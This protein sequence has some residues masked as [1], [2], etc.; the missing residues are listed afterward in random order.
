MDDSPSMR[1]SIR[2]SMI[3]PPPPLPYPYAQA[4]SP[5]NPAMDVE[6]DFHVKNTERSS[7]EPGRRVKG[8]TLRKKNL[9]KSQSDREVLATTVVSL[10]DL[11][12]KTSP[13][14]GFGSPIIDM[15]ASFNSGGS[16][17]YLADGSTTHDDFNFG[18]DN[19]IFVPVEHDIFSDDDDET[20]GGSGS[21]TSVTNFNQLSSSKN[22]KG[23]S[24]RTNSRK[25]RLKKSPSGRGSSGENGKRWTLSSLGSFLRKSD[26][27]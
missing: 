5:S 9:K 13:G 1:S 12:G 7:E 4:S 10:N 8:A 2:D 23:G 20:F 11:F 16:S 14:G 17:V 22:S 18:S 25:S 15:G 19:P 26:K 27:I 21:S 6:N 3:P 24:F